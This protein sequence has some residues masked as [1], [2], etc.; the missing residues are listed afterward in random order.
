MK[1][2]MLNMMAKER[3]DNFY[4]PVEAMKILIKHLPKDIKIW[5][6]TDYGNSHITKELV[7]SGYKVISSDIIY[8]FDFLKD[9]MN[10]KDFDMIITNPPYSLKD[11]FLERC[12]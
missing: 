3:Y 12:Y 9:T 6:C 11:K 2:P 1:Q 7:K 4:T 5:E 8:G 10:T